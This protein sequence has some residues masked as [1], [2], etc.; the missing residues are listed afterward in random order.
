MRLLPWFFGPAL[1]ASAFESQHVSVLN[2]PLILGSSS[3]ERISTKTKEL[4]EKHGVSVAYI[5]Q[6]NSTPLF[7]AART[8]GNAEVAS[9]LVEKG[10]DASHLD[11]NQ[12]T[13]QMSRTA[14]REVQWK[15]PW[16]LGVQ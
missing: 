15:G 4:V 14:A 2:V 10:C 5:D 6:L 16:R 11:Q 8:K 9:Y 13:L 7:H 1:P 12:E 3:C